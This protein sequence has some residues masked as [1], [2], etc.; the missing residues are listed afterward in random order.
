VPHD[1]R[2]EIVDFVNS[3]SEKTEI[4][5]MHLVSWLGVRRGKFHDWKG[6]Y[7]KVN[8]HNS[9][10]P[11]DHWLEDWEKK[12]VI[13][14]YIEHPFDGYRRLT[15][16]M[17]DADVVAVSPASVYRVLRDAGLMEPQN[18]RSS[19]KGTGFVQPTAPH[20]HWHVDLAYLNLGG[21]FYYLCA[22]I[23][24]YSRYIVH[25]DIMPSMTSGDVQ[26]VVQRAREMFPGTSP[27]VIS[28]NGPQFVARDFKVFIRETQMTHVR[29]SPYYP[30][31][32]GKIER[33]VLTYR[34][35]L[36]FINPATFEEAYTAT[37]EIMRHYNEDRL[38]SG[39]GYVTPRTKLEGRDEE[40][41]AE[42]DRKIEAARAV[43]AAA[44]AEM[45]AEE[46]RTAVV[47]TCG[48]EAVPA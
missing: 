39:I 27:R 12:A 38:H 32:N 42:R 43:R 19:K 3:W 28:D 31:S 18:G 14:Y 9:W 45:H 40:V 26:L 46:Q 11:R 7:G 47:S 44:R 17:L 33:F 4:P 22:I 36:R 41:F 20:Q 48:A 30:Q 23:D 13:D 2:D 6:R 8:E 5:N 16:M 10:I 34:G 29:T 25:W 15:F 24:G 21:T 1:T 35:A 37:A